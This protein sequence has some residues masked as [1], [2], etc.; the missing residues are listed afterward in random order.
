MRDR[1]IF[2]DKSIR[3]I[4]KDGGYPMASRTAKRITKK[5]DLDYLFNM[6]EEVACKTSTIMECFGE[7]GDKRRFNPYDILDVPKGTYGVEGH[8][9]K[10]PFTTTVGL[11]IFNK[12]FIEQDLTGIIPYVNET[13]TKKV[14]KRIN[15]KLSH[16]VIEDRLKLDALKR[17][18][19]KGQKFQPYSNILCP[20]FSGAMISVSSRIDKQRTKLFKEHEKEIK[21]DKDPVVMQDIEKKL[22]DACKKDLKDDPSL[23]M[24]NSGAAADYGNNF[25][26]MFVCKGASKLSDPRLGNFSMIESNLTDGI[27]PDEYADFCESL[28][29]GP[30]ARAKKTAEGGAWEKIFVKALEHLTIIPNSDCKTKKTKEVLLTEDE[31]KK[32]MYSYIVD[33]KGEYVELTEEMLPKYLNKKVRFRYSALCEHKK[34]I[35]SICA[36]N[37]FN[38]IGIKN[39]G[40]AAYKVCSDLKNASMKS[41]HDSTVKITSMKDYDLNKIFG[42][43]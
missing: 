30:Y 34:G 15:T 18:I 40:I 2:R 29:G 13:I 5:E 28:T 21:E 35:C 32:W 25:K 22:I 3:Y 17:F 12:A 37:L 19:L 41:F 10:Y 7:F 43:K 11:W 23:D 24:L 20:S 36:G 33:S 16:A 14:Y 31:A 39:I 4:A 38:R 9:N 8:K 27:Q 1:F 42:L 6:T 26:N